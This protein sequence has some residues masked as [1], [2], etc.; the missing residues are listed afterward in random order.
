MLPKTEWDGLAGESGS[1]VRLPYAFHSAAEL[2]E[3]AGE[4]SLSIDRV[5]LANECER[6]RAGRTAEVQP[7]RWRARP[8]RHPSDLGDYAGMR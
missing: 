2:L 3:A 7:T 5:M 8:I 1:E 4:H 6:L